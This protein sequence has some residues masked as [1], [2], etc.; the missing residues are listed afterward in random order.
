MMTFDEKLRTGYYND[1]QSTAVLPKQPT[2]SSVRPGKEDIAKYEKALD[3]Y[4]EALEVYRV[5]RNVELTENNH[6]KEQF[7]HD[8][9][10]EYWDILEQHTPLLDAMYSFAWDYGHADGYHAVA[11]IFADLTPIIKELRRLYGVQNISVG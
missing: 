5:R 3:E 1:I 10:K 9:F 11:A 2:L 8:L 4:Y 7:K 6:R